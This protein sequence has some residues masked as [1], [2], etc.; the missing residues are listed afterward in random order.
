VGSEPTGN[1]PHGVFV[2]LTTLDII[3]RVRGLPGRNAKVTALR[4]DVA[5]GGP[6]L[7]AAVVFAALGGRA[8]L[9]SRL[10]QGNLASLIRDDIE[11]YGVKVADLAEASFRP[12]VSTITVDEATG[13]RQIVSTDAG[14]EAG[15]PE[16][17]VSP[18]GRE[19]GEVLEIIG[20]AD[21]VHFDGHHPDLTRA[22]ARW[23]S[24]L[25]VPLVV[26]AGRWKPVMAELVPLSTDIVC[27]AD[28]TVPGSDDEVLSWILSQ[29]AELAAVT[30][31]SAPVRWKTTSAQGSVEVEQI[32]A[33]DT[34]GAGDFFHGAYSFARTFHDASG[35]QLDAPACLR[36]ACHI[37]ALKCASPGTRSWLD[38]MDGVSP[39]DYLRNE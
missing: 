15:A 18:D 27:S 22:A 10:G 33:V 13:D 39:L 26:D 8:T 31:G 3:Q 28:F 25:A 20:P 11:S 19:I 2:G 4:Q 32:R 17:S 6:A 5:G 21:I 1:P 35:R 30:S 34:L 23:G 29:G 38:A 16:A 14:V 24:G 7:N 36:F 37:A 12:S 9:V